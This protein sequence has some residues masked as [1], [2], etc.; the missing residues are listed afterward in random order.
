MEVDRLCRTWEWVIWGL[1]VRGG[2]WREV[3]VLKGRSRKAMV[4]ILSE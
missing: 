4:D 1:A 2:Q 3:D